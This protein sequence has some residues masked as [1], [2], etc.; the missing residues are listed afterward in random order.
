[1]AS[2]LLGAPPMAFL[3]LSLS[4]RLSSTTSQTLS[5]SL[6]S[7]SYVLSR[8]LP[9]ALPHF[10][11]AHGAFNTV[12]SSGIGDKKT[13]KGKRFNHSFSNVCCSLDS[14]ANC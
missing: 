14:F 6:S 11:L 1:M 8:S 9:S 13:A 5:Q 4:P 10:L 3:S 7:S 2:Q 12:V